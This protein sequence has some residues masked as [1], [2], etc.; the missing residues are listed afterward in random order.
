MVT[1]RSF[2]D[3]G[4]P[5]GR[6]TTALPR[7]VKV[8]LE[9]PRALSAPI[10]STSERYITSS[11]PFCQQADMPEQEFSEVPLERNS[12]D[13]TEELPPVITEVYVHYSGKS[14]CAVGR[15]FMGRYLPTE[16]RNRGSSR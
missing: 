1:G 5:R 12:N 9:P 8:A 6:R 3:A 11:A 7:L 15:W 14:R 13:R 16:Y 4:G 2:P 10:R